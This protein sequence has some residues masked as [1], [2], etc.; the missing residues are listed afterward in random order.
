MS[1]VRAVYR[2]L[3]RESTRCLDY[4]IKHFIRRRIREGF[5]APL[6]SG[7]DVENRI[8]SAHDELESVRR[9]VTVNNLYN[10]SQSVIEAANPTR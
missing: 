8:Q 10:D 1:Q 6:I 3:W 9:I 7:A 5:R 4:N 2:S